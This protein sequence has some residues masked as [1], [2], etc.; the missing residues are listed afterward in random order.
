MASKLSVGN[1]FVTQKV[2]DKAI[3]HS[4]PCSAT[5]VQFHCHVV[6]DEVNEFIWTH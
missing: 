3:G 1:I 2:G 6:Y 4:P 5:P